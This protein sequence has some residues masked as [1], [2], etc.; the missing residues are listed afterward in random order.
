MNMFQELMY[1]REY[2]NTTGTSFEKFFKKSSI[3]HTRVGLPELLWCAVEISNSMPTS[4][5]VK[6]L[7]ET[8]SIASYFNKKDIKKEYCYDDVDKEVKPK[9]W[10]KFCGSRD[11]SE[12]A[13]FKRD[14]YV[15]VPVHCTGCGKDWNDVYEFTGELAEECRPCL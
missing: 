6:F 14:R 11:L 10:C 3:D 5:G 2:I 7:E 4:E 12:G 1:G 13:P 8:I 15:F 9:M